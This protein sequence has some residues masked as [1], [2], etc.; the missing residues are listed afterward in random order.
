MK[1]GK[2][3]VT[4]DWHLFHLRLIESGERPADY[5][6]RLLRNHRRRIGPNDTVY[7]LGDVCFYQ[8]PQLRGI[9]ASIPGTH[10]LVMGNHD[11]KSR[12]WYG[13]N[14]FT[15]VADLIR[16]GDVVL[17]H[18]PLSALP[19][20]ARVNVHG[21]LHTHRDYTEKQAWHRLVA[22]EHTDYEPVLLDQLIG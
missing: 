9:L 17:S 12:N 22:L 1:P 8:L 20:E 19:D 4:T 10:H 7:N 14:G 3:W 13:R 18:K 15:F 21:H 11:H 2:T 5:Q 16:I 6:D